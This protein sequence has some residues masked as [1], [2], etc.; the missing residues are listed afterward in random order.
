M[1]I[2]SY[3]LQESKANIPIVAESSN[4]NDINTM[5]VP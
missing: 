1:A 2:P 4:N 3:T 5:L